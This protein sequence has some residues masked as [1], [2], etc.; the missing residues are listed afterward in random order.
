MWQFFSYL[1]RW[2]IETWELL[3]NF[4]FVCPFFHLLVRYNYLEKNV[5]KKESWFK[6]GTQQNLTFDKLGSKIE[7]RQVCNAAVGL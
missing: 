4:S 2:V 1:I 7:G 6:V 5:M 3:L